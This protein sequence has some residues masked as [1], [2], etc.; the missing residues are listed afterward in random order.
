[1]S[2]HPSQAGSNHFAPPTSPPPAASA[3]TYAPPS[4][5]PPT[6]DASGK[7]LSGEEREAWQAA[8]EERE[9]EF[10]SGAANK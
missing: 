1:M 7:E 2:S 10:S 3:S 8:Q 6:H 4:G 9:R 5:A